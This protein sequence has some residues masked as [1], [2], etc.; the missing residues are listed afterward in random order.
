MKHLI[1]VITVALFAAGCGSDEAGDAD[2]V[3]V[4]KKAHNPLASE[5]QLIR[6]AKMVQGLVDTDAERKKKA[7]AASN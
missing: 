2:Q 3:V 5:Q 6:D 7:L 4:K 1:L